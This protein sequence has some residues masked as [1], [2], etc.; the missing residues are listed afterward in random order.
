MTTPAPTVGPIPRVIYDAQPVP[1]SG[2]GLYAAARIINT[3]HRELLA[4][5]ELWPY[6]C[7]TDGVGTYPMDICNDDPEIKDPGSRAAPIP[8]D[9]VVIWSASECR[10]DQT[11]DEVIARA[12]HNLELHEPTRVEQIFADKLLTD[13]GVPA[14][15]PDFPTAIGM[16][17]EWMGTQGYQGYIHLSRK[18]AA[19][20][21][22]YRWNNQSGPTFRS[23]LDHGYIFGSGY[24]DLGDTLIITGPV[25]VWR[26]SLFEQV[27]TDGTH[28]QSELQNLVY[29]MVERVVTVGFECSIF[30]VTVETP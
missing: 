27:R 9:P 30:A 22:Q 8:F 2:Y 25:T 14:S 7:D 16:L 20:A 12:R 17:E 6:N 15:A 21:S 4:G 13:A 24:S 11:E 26:S 10:P 19:L 3:D 18:W 5:L 28:P 29:G 1:P 23:P